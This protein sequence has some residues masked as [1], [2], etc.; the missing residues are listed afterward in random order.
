L[1]PEKDDFLL[2]FNLL[3]LNAFKKNLNIEYQQFQDNKK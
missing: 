1:E 2:N 3:K